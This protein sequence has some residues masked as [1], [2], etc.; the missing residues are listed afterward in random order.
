MISIAINASG[1][2]YMDANN[3]LAIVTDQAAVEQDV[4]LATYLFLGEFP[5]DTTQGVDYFG[6]VFNHKNPYAFQNSLKSAIL[7]VPN[8]TDVT[9]LTI[10]L[11]GD[12]LQYQATIDSAFGSVPV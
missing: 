6:T 9:N 11:N 4:L 12:E 10:G 1:D 2:I 8:T 7:T 5:Y 3:N